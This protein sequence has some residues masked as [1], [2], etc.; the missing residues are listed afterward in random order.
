MIDAFCRAKNF[1]INKVDN[2]NMIQVYY[3]ISELVFKIQNAGSEGENLPDY[4]ELEDYHFDW[5]EH[6][7]K[8]DSF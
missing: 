7:L 6:Q 2:P 1:A 8:G 4:K 5:I 3:E